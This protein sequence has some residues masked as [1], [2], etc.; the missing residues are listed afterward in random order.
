MHNPSLVLAVPE[1]PGVNNRRAANVALFHELDRL[2]YVYWL[3]S[4]PCAS[5]IAG[6][7]SIHHHRVKLLF[8]GKRQNLK[9]CFKIQTKNAFVWFLSTPVFMQS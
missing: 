7:A 2:S 4:L 3:C 5:N 8:R 1:G 9:S 6:G